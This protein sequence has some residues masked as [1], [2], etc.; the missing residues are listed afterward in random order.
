VVGGICE[1][2]SSV[3][4]LP[5]E[6]HYDLVIIADYDGLP[7]EARD[8]IVSRFAGSDVA[9]RARLLLISSRANRDELAGLF[10]RR[11]L[12]N[13]LAKNGDVDPTELI[14]TVQKIL[15]RD[16]FGL[17]KYFAW[18]VHLASAR[19]NASAEKHALLDRVSRYAEQLG[20]PSRLAAQ[21]CLVTD[22]IVTNAIYNAP[23]DASGQRRY[24]HLPRTDALTLPPG[25]GIDVR[26]C[27]DG[28]RLGV[29][30]VDPYGSLSEECIL[31]YLGRCF[32]APLSKIDLDLTKGGAGLG[33]YYVF[34]AV[35]HLVINIAPGQRTEVIGLF[36][37][38]ESYR[39]FVTNSKSFNVFL[40]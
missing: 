37:L 8:R 38:H 27:S 24:A 16:V 7:T 31:E 13:L 18:G 22:E 15:R 10:S 2:R 4:D 36:D 25:E 14:V 20:M 32:A 26:F 29:S 17:E 39:A 1:T 23:T 12:T 21:V 9:R 40:A 19:L 11:A 28:R 33:L 3:D 6:L 30:A 34:E 5:V 35:S